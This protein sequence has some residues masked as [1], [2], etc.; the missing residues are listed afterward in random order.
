MNLY[1]ARKY[2]AYRVQW[3][4]IGKLFFAGAAMAGTAWLCHHALV[5]LSGNTVA[6]LAAIVAAAVVYVVGLI[7]FRA[8]SAEDAARL[9]VVGGKLSR[10]MQKISG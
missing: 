5:N 8:V 9:P 7:L 2:I 3:G 10:L 1:F 6:T 4:Y